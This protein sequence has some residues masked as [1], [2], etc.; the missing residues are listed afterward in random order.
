M[1][2]KEEKHGAYHHGDLR[3]SMI[4]HALS[5]IDREGIGGLTLRKAARHAGVS[6]AAPAHH[7]GD[8]KGLLAAIAEQGFKQMIRQMEQAILLVPAGNPLEKLKSIGM[9]YIEYAVKNPSSFRIMYHPELSMKS[10]HAGLEQQSRKTFEL[11]ME[12]IAE[13]QNNGLIAAGDIREQSLFAWSTVHGLSIL[14]V[15]GQL[16]SKG[17]RS[18]TMQYAEKM[19]DLLYSGLGITS[20][21]V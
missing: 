11:L 1:N 8:K 4:N 5:I 18:S 17:F 20:P 14:I 16:K 21:S 13:C 3:N 19:T 9:A 2:N 6:H 10:V 7:F 12:S 15:D